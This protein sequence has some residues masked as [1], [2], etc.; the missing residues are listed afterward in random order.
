MAAA[1]Q[2][3]TDWQRNADEFVD[4]TAAWIADGQALG[5]IQI[6][7]P[8]VAAAVPQRYLAPTA[9]SAKSII[10]ENCDS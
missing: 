5:I 1:Q 10:A 8:A 2:R 3:R 9:A 7:M 4:A 6:Q